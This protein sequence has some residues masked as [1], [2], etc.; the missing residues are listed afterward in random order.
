VRPPY[1]NIESPQA[2]IAWESRALGQTDVA[3]VAVVVRVDEVEVENAVVGVIVVAV[4][5]VVVVVLVAVVAA[6]VVVV[7]T[8]EPS[9]IQRCV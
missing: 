5:T 8:A 9:V 1:I 7:V 2:H 3:R 6:V 4:E